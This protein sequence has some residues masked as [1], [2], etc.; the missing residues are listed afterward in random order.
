M[1]N[2]SLRYNNEPYRYT[3]YFLAML[4]KNTPSCE[5]QTVHSLHQ[6]QLEKKNPP[7]GPPPPPPPP[8]TPPPPPPTKKRRGASTP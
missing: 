8:P 4:Y 6:T 1:L 7:Q 2:M 5:Q 3:R